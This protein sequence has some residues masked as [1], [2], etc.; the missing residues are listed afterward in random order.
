[1]CKEWDWFLCNVGV[2]ESNL[3]MVL[4][5]EVWEDI[6]CDLNGVKDVYGE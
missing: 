1:M 2:D 3:I 4:S 5:V 6:L